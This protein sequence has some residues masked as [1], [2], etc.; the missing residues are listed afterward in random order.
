MP[1]AHPDFF[2]YEIDLRFKNGALADLE[3]A[4]F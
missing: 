2:F 1:F 3:E 4:D